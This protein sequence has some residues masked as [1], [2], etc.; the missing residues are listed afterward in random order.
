MKKCKIINYIE[1]MRGMKVFVK[2]NVYEELN[3]KL[4]DLNYAM[5]KSKFLDLVELLGNRKELFFRNIWTGIV[6]GIGIGIGVTIITAIIVI[7]LQK[8]VTWNIP[9][10]GEYIADI[11]DIVENSRQQVT[12]YNLQLKQKSQ[13]M[14]IFYFA[15]QKINHEL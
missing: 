13:M 8:I 12:S 4:D 10:I 14:Y 11:V 3:K 2:N 6:K 7:I 15:K 1:L 9:V 5:T